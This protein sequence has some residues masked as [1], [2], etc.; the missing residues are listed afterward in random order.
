MPGSSSGEHDPDPAVVVEVHLVSAQAGLAIGEVAGLEPAEGVDREP[1]VVGVGLR[2]LQ[3]QRLVG[4]ELPEAAA[5][6]DVVGAT[7]GRPGRVGDVGGGAMPT[8]GRVVVPERR[9]LLDP[10]RR[11]VEGTSDES[12]VEEG[13]RD[14]LGTDPFDVEDG[15]GVPLPVALEDADGEQPAVG[16]GGQPVARLLLRRETKLEPAVVADLEVIEA[17]LAEDPELSQLHLALVEGEEGLA[18]TAH[19][20]PDAIAL[21]GVD[22]GPQVGEVGIRATPLVVRRLVADEDRMIGVAG[23]HLHLG[24]V[25][26][27]AGEPAEP[28]G[29]IPRAG[30]EALGQDR[31][32]DR[33]QPV[34]ELAPG[35][36]R[37]QPFFVAPH[38]RPSGPGRAPR[39]SSATYPKP[40][41][42]RRYVTGT[43]GCSESL[44]VQVP[45]Q[46]DGPFT[47]APGEPDLVEQSVRHVVDESSD[48]LLVR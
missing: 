46:R 19:I 17:A 44:H 14:P 41:A 11:A 6:E 40:T 21:A 30:G 5:V 12:G 13:R 3:H 37:H 32:A 9:G 18:D 24:G 42:Q 29:P 20:G 35:L 28:L 16:M 15:S 43:T 22:V 10:G 23:L 2:A 34:A 48:V 26:D 27:Q 7:R 47:E 45:M 36:A 1:P 33:F 25:G 31:V 8:F 4:L 38:R 39:R